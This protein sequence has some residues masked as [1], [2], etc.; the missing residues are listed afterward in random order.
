MTREEF[1]AVLAALDGVTEYVYY[2]LMGEPLLHPDLPTLLSM[3]R[4]R[5]FHSV[6]TTNGTLL[7]RRG[8]AILDAGVHKVS[9]SLHS[10]E[11]GGEEAMHRYLSEVATFA[12]TATARGVIVV[13]RLWNRGFDG[14]RND[15]ILDFL[16]HRLTGEWAEN[17]RGMRVREKLYVEWGDRFAWPDRDAPDGGEDVFCYGLSDHFGILV[18]GTVVPCCLDSEGDIPLGNLFESPLTEILSSPRAR[19]IKEGF[20]RR[21]ACESLC[22]RCGYARRFK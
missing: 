18:D 3:A 6:I 2:H 5:G 8:T 20:S 19:A 10:L 22:R 17:T 13:L 11:S 1:A 14:G 16:R 7:S 12:D 9:V 4:E 21:H 15:Q